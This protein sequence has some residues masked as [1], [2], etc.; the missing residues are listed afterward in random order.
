MVWDRGFW[1]PETK[2]SPA[3]S[4]RD[5]EFKFVMAG[6][7]I[8]GSFVLVRLRRRGSEKRDNWLL[9]KHKDEF[10]TPGKDTIQKNDRSV[11]SGRTMGQ[12]AKGTGNGAAPFITV[13]LI[14]RIT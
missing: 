4:L 12:I 5:G 14:R 2:Q 1:A 6:E 9:I 3:Q 11:A 8:K 7:K 13:P 10:A